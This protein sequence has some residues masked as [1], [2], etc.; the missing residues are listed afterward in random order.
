MEVGRRV[1]WACG[2]RA[3][4]PP[5]VG[6]RK[7][8]ESGTIPLVVM[9]NDYLRIV[10][11]RAVRI[12]LVSCAGRAKKITKTGHFGTTRHFYSQKRTADAYQG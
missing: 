6:P 4:Q 7:I 12:V 3:A 8:S 10:R 2:A 11:H 1:G 9:G 5:F